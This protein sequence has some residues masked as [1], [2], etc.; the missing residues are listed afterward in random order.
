MDWTKESIKS[1]RVR[2]GL[3]Q[4]KFAKK[5]RVSYC[6]V[7][8]WEQGINHPGEKGMRK[9]NRLLERVGQ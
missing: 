9:L 7:R 5:L 8:N 3:T 4:M 2:L 1:L 6:C